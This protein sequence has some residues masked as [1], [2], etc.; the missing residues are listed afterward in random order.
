MDYEKEVVHQNLNVFTFD[1]IVGYIET[2][3]DLGVLNLKQAAILHR[4][5][6]ARAWSINPHL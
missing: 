2:S 6:S 5:P 3:V 4:L 1:Q